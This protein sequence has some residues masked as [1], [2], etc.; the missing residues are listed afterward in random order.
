MT[1]FICFTMIMLEL[2]VFIEAPNPG[3]AMSIINTD[4]IYIT[5]M[6]IYLFNKKINYKTVTGMII[7]LI[8]ISII[9][10][11]NRAV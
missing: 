10:L 1:A 5:L 9:N 6:S 11:T 4:V 2:S 7:A 3:Y 8:G